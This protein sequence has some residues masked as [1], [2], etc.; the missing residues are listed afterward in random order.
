MPTP[1]GD[2]S[3]SAMS[4]IAILGD[5]SSEAKAAADAIGA[6]NFPFKILN[7]ENL[8]SI[9]AS[10]LDVVVL[11]VALLSQK[12]SHQELLGK[13]VIVVGPYD[14]A[15]AE[16]VLEYM[17]IDTLFA[18]V[19][20]YTTEEFQNHVMA[21]LDQA[22]EA[23]QATES[24]AMFFEHN[25][26]LQRLSEELEERIELRRNEL[27]DSTW[28]LQQSQR[29]SEI[30]HRALNA[31]HISQSIPEIE[32]HLMQILS[33]TNTATSEAPQIDWVRITFSSQSR[34][35]AAPMD[36]RAGTVYSVA[37]GI[38]GHIHF[39]RS[40]DRPFRS[41]DRGFLN[42]IAEAVT[43][44]VTRLR[45]LER[46]EQIKHEWEE[47]F[48]AITHPVAVLD[49]NLRL[50]RGNRALLKGRA[51][52]QVVGRPCFEAVFERKAACVG[53]PVMADYTSGRFRQRRRSHE[54]GG[55]T[56]G[57]TVARTAQFRIDDQATAQTSEVS[58]RPL[59]I[60]SAASGL[61]DRG[62]EAIL[63]HLYRDATTTVQFEKRIVESSKMAELGT[64]GSSIA[65][66]LNNP[67]G[68]MLSHI[69]LLLMD[70]KTLKFKGKEELEVEL[71]EMEN[72]TRRC[73]EIV[74]DLLGFS[75][76]ADEDEAHE[77][78]LIE[79]VRQA[80]KITELQTRS[81][82]IRFKLELEP[83]NLDEAHIQGRF[84]LLA[85]AVRA[86]LLTLLSGSLR[87]LMINL[88]IVKSSDELTIVIGPVPASNDGLLERG[89]RSDRLDL[90]VARQIL[91]EHGGRLELETTS[92]QIETGKEQLVQRAILSLPLPKV[93]GP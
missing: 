89:D 72:G 59:N 39:G 19:E 37:T 8:K 31:V 71:R 6:A 9:R 24:L 45:S 36:K 62:D 80:M 69:Q 48:N 87:D 74:R 7:S 50:V 22:R 29:K 12:S 38:N 4:S 88:K 52:E 61:V 76:R 34:L 82:G 54:G 70:L 66:Q 15:N 86:I 81:K 78:D 11:P 83:S 47:T 68:G 25:Q 85:Q 77:H 30:M 79:I 93:L 35:D 46:M 42:P 60:D 49:E 10:N 27:N 65:H 23:K 75:R 1:S 67:I 21:A 26:T 2:M 90:T 57:G 13:K 40:P 63:V 17:Q 58:S 51:A 44:A 33:T 56:I 41:D 84:N 55:Q 20:S 14:D 91:L 32:R 73:A 3:T 43:L 53:C 28:R 64:I 92:A 16:S 5:E 18:W